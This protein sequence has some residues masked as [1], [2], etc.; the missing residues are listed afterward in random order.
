MLNVPP[1]HPKGRWARRRS[2]G[3]QGA[4]HRQGF[5]LLLRPH[6]LRVSRLWIQPSRGSEVH[7]CYDKIGVKAMQTCRRGRCVRV[8]QKAI[9]DLESCDLLS[10]AG[11]KLRIDRGVDVNPVRT[12]A[13]LA[14]STELANNGTCDLRQPRVQLYLYERRLTFHSVIDVRVAEHN[15]WCIPPSFD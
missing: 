7:G 5:V 2:R 14:G 1:G 8:A 12:D 6:P 15:E 13:S 3:R 9:S 4:F 10:Q 11:R